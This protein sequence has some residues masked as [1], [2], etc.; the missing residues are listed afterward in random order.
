MDHPPHV[1]IFKKMSLSLLRILPKLFLFFAIFVIAFHV[2]NFTDRIQYDIYGIGAR[3][4]TIQEILTV[5]ERYPIGLAN[6][7]K[8]ELAELIYDEATR[9]HHDPKFILALITIESSFQNRSIS[10][11]GAR[12]LM[13]IMPCVAESLAQE[14]GIEWKGDHTLFDPFLNVRIGIYYLSRLNLDFND[15]RIALTAYNCGPTFVKNLMERKKKIPLWYYR[16]IL[17]VYH[18][19]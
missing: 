14:M 9:Y 15:M 13:Q 18:N 2:P 19:L 3:E 6:V 7:K 16:R 10:E 1:S 5:L 11:R 8:E 17:T 12:G 4:E